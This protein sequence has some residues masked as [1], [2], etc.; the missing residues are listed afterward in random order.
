MGEIILDQVQNP[1][2]N[3]RRLTPGLV[4]SSFLPSFTDRRLIREQ[5]LGRPFWVAGATLIR[6]NVPFVNALLGRNWLSE[7]PLNT[8]GE[9]KR[10][11]EVS[12]KQRDE[13]KIESRRRFVLF[14]RSKWIWGF[15]TLINQ[16]H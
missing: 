14:H 2:S 7:T 12:F 6:I 11:G 9:T 16:Y 8:P 15:Y 10:R 1:N 4:Y 13:V 5:L 3:P